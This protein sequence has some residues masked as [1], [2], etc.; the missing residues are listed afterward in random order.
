M[1]MICA[2]RNP[3]DPVAALDQHLTP[4]GLVPQ[5]ANPEDPV[6][7][8][9]GLVRETTDA[10]AGT[11]TVYS[12]QVGQSATG[13]LSSSADE[14]WF[15]ITLV[16]GQTYSF[17]LL[18]FGNDYLTDPFLRL[19][20]ASGT[21]IAYDD[22]AFTSGSNTHERDSQL[23]F[24][25]STTGTYYLAADAYS[26]ETGRYLLTATAHDPNGRV[27]TVDEMAWQLINNGNAF[28][29]SPEAVAFDLGPDN[30]LTV[31]LTGLTAAGQFLARE[32]LEV[33]SAYTG[34][35]FQEV[36]GAAEI[37][38]DDTENGAF[39]QP[40]SSG[41]RIT[42]STVNVGLDWLQ[43]FGTGL[44]SYSFETYLHEI[45]HALGLAH[46]GN[47]N[48]SATY[49]IDNFYLNDSVAWTIMSYMNAQNDEFDT[50]GPNDWNTYVNAAF[51]YI[52]SPMI[53]DM[54]AMQ[55][56]YGVS[57]AFAGSTTYGFG[58]NTGVTAIDQ[59]VNSG[60]LMAMTIYDTGGIDTLNFANTSAHQIISLA[61]ESL[62]SVLGGRNNLG[63]A[64]GTVIE[65]AISGSGNDSLI[66]NDAN[67][68]LQANAGADTV[69]GGGGN[70]SL[71]GGAGRNQLFGDDGHDYIEAGHDGDFIGGGTGNDTIRGGNGADTIYGGT[72]N[73]NIG[74]GA[75]SDLI[76]AVEGRNIIWGGLGNDTVQGGTGGDEIYGGAGRNQL[77]GNDGHDYIEAGNEGDLIGGGAGHDIIRGGNGADTIYGGAGN[78][79][80]YGSAGRDILTGS[81]GA[82]VFVFSTAA[83][84][85]IGAGRDVITDFT[86]GVDDIDLRG[87]ATSFNTGGTL[88]GGG[89]R[90]FYYLA[91]SGLLIGDQ[92]GDGVADWVLELTGAPAVTVNDFLL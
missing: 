37:T 69:Y 92:N 44:Q 1:C 2:L 83:A 8:G 68:I 20:D 31:N 82:D 49:G 3:T 63:I 77:F 34:I 24:T 42:S 23:T 90:S 22:D 38:F 29:S 73:D 27:F 57:S 4:D 71:Y 43:E 55:Y 47:Y 79:T 36:N 45:G 16:A 39:A 64:R 81:S 88:T 18:G 67:N 26:S 78:D 7:A 70:D 53:V 14:D 72:G 32:A 33:W 60:A 86:P 41:G 15:S 30:A 12:L 58:S 21:Q 28:F 35:Q 50:G 6:W 46:G 91:S 75:G 51:R 54:I 80:I 13:T 76:Y 89:I 59:A 52:Y 9:A 40:I 48:G 62:S 74:G 65:N 61:Q 25:A 85:G 84:I 10:A 87:L 5:A 11:G 66:G 17:R 19:F 56:L